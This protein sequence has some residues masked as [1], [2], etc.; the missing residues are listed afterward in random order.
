MVGKS[1][2]TSFVAWYR[3]GI[4]AEARMLALSTYSGHVNPVDTYWY[5]S[6][7]PELVELVAERLGDRPAGVKR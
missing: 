1:L 7:S 4:A 5:L 6:T 3:S 2:I